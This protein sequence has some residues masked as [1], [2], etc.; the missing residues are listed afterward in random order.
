MTE[1]PR[2]G[3]QNPAEIHTCT[4]RALVLADKLRQKWWRW[5][6]TAGVVEL[7]AEEELRRLH[8]ENEELRR[9]IRI[10]VKAARKADTP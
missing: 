1:C 8:A 5:E 6:G 4:P 3:K 7:Q 2:C 10:M 9:T